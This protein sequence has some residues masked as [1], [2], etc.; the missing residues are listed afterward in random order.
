MADPT[1]DPGGDLYCNGSTDALCQNTIPTWLLNFAADAIPWFAIVAVICALAFA[2][3]RT[4]RL[5][6]HHTRQRT[7]D[8][9][10]RNVDA[11]TGATNTLG[12]MMP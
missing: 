4:A 10:D 8:R 12:P 2:C 1:L 5:I 9:R 7:S 6:R 11:T 3:V